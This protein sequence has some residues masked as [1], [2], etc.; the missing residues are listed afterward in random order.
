M[1]TFFSEEKRLKAL[2]KQSKAAFSS[3]ISTHAIPHSPIYTDHEFYIAHLNEFKT[4]IRHALKSTM[5]ILLNLLI[6]SMGYS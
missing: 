1:F 6:L 4:Q 2:S 5:Q 3:S